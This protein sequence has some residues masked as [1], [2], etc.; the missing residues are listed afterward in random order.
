ML[1]GDSMALDSTGVGSKAGANCRTTEL[2]DSINSLV[3]AP[4]LLEHLQPG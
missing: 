1:E 3:P 2:P 4:Q